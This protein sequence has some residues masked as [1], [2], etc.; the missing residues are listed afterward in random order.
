MK[1]K[2]KVSCLGCQG[3]KDNPDPPSRCHPPQYRRTSLLFDRLFDKLKVPSMV[4]GLMSLRKPKCCVYPPLADC[5][6]SLLSFDRLTILP[7]TMSSGRMERSRRTC[8]VL[9]I[10]LSRRSSRTQQRDLLCGAPAQ[11]PGSTTCI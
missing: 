10:R 3:N 1:R 8:G 4:E 2:S 11:S 5:L 7:S 6:R 9:F